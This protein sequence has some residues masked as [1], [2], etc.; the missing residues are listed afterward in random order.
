LLSFIV[1]NYS[2]VDWNTETQALHAATVEQ[3]IIDKGVL[4][5]EVLYFTS[6]LD[7]QALTEEEVKSLKE[8]YIQQAAVKAALSHS[9]AVMSTDLEKKEQIDVINNL[10]RQAN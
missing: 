7:K 1:Q 5:N 4:L 10:L 6:S 3:A 9:M 8:Q 2:Y